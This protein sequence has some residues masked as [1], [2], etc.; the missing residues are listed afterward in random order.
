MSIASYERRDKS[1]SKCCGMC[2]DSIQARAVTGE[3][4]CENFTWRR[5]GSE[6]DLVSISIF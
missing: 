1:N 5:M 6:F 2:A 4:M 3:R